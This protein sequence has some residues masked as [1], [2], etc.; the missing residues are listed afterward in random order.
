MFTSFVRRRVCHFAVAVAALLTGSIV[1]AAPPATAVGTYLVLLDQTYST[2][3][4]TNQG[5]AGAPGSA[6]CRII[7]GTF[8][9]APLR[10]IY[11]PSTGHFQ[12]LHNNLS[13]KVTVRTL[14]GT[15]S[16]ATAGAPAHMAGTMH[17]MN[18]AFGSLGEYPFSGTKQ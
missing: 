18:A 10:G 2:L 5:G 16:A 14:T 6:T 12:I 7:L 4:I 11:C 9:V 15:L 13:T 17:V 1:A 8:D 3:T